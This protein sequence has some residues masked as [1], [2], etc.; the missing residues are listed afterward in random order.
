MVLRY[1]YFGISIVGIF[2]FFFLLKRFFR[3]LQSKADKIDRNVLFKKKEV[4]KLFKFITPR[5]EAYHKVCNSYFKDINQSFFLNY[6][7]AFCF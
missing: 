3:W 4:A 5:R 2:I 6:L 7:F 1:V